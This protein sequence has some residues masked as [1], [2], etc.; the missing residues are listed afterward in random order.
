[1]SS[2]AL[3]A[4]ACSL[5]L[6]VSTAFADGLVKNPGFETGEE[7]W[8]LFLPA[9]EVGTEAVKWAILGK[10]EFS[11]EGQSVA[12]LTGTDPIRWGISGTSFKVSE[13]QKY[14]ISAW[15]KFDQDAQILDKAK[16]HAYVR[17]TML[18]ASGQDVEGNDFGHFHIGLSGDVAGNMKVDKLR[19]P[20]L[21]MEWRKIEGVIQIM[22]GVSKLNMTLFINGVIG[23]AYWDDLSIEEMPDEIPLSR[24]LE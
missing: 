3:V 12:A 23:T 6:L 5:L 11:H 10:S 20:E 8:N 7:G 17:A 21:P 22:P 14:R 15:V 24:I 1:M 9:E 4:A 16:V 13:G 2:H 18:D 19:L